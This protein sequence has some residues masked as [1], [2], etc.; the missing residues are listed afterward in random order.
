ME[1]DIDIE[2]HNVLDNP[3]IKNMILDISN[4]KTEIE[5]YDE[6]GMSMDIEENYHNIVFEENNQFKT[7]SNKII[8]GSKPS[9]S[10]LIQESESETTVFEEDN[11]DASLD[12]TAEPEVSDQDVY[13]E[14]ID[15]TVPAVIDQDVYPE[16][17]DVTLPIVSDQNVYP[18]TSILQGLLEEQ[19]F[20][21]KIILGTKTPDSLDDSDYTDN[22]SVHDLPEVSVVL[23]DCKNFLENNPCF[24]KDCEILFATDNDL[25]AHRMTVHS[26]LVAVKEER[27]DHVIPKNIAVKSTSKYAY[28]EHHNKL[29][30]NHCNVIFPSDIDLLKHTYELLPNKSFRKVSGSDANKMAHYDSSNLKTTTNLPGMFFVCRICTCH[31]KVKI[32]LQTH[33]VLFHCIK[34][35]GE[36][37]PELTD[38]RCRIC[39][40]KVKNGKLYNLHVQLRHTD[41]YRKICAEEP[42]QFKCHLCSASFSSDYSLRIHLAAKHSVVKKLEIEEAPASSKN[43]TKTV[44][45]G[46]NAPVPK[47]TIFKCNKCHVHF[48]SCTTAVTHLR[49]CSLRGDFRCGR[50]RRHFNIIEKFDHLHQHNLT[51]RFRVIDIS[52]NILNKILCK[53]NKCNTCFDEVSLKSHTAAVCSAETPAIYCPACN[54]WINATAM[55]QHKNIHASG[56]T[57]SDFI[58][59]V[60]VHCNAMASSDLNEDLDVNIDELDKVKVKQEFKETK[61][62][63]KAPTKIVKLKGSVRKG[64]EKR[65][66]RSD[67]MAYLF[68]PTCKCYMK[69]N[70][71]TDK[72]CIGQCSTK[73]PFVTCKCCGLKF[74]QK[75]YQSHCKIHKKYPKLKLK[76]MNFTN[77]QTYNRMN[78][79]FPKFE[80]CKVCKVSFF[81]V[82]ALKSHVCNAEKPKLCSHCDR[83]F[84]DLAYNLHV[85]FYEYPHRYKTN[86]NVKPTN[87]K[88]SKVNEN[89]PELMKKYK[90]LKQIWNILFLC[91]TCDI[92]ID[93]YDRVVEHCQD[94]FCNM[95]SYNVTI[96]RCDICNLNFVDESFKKHKELHS[97]DDFN[98]DSFKIIEYSYDNLL[99]NN[100]LQIFESLTQEQINLILSKSMY[101]YSRCVRMKLIRNGPAAMVLYQC[102]Q[103]KLIVVPNKITEHSQNINGQCQT[104]RRFN[105]SICS[106]KFSYKSHKIVHEKLHE[107]RKVTA[108]SFKIVEF[109]AE[110]QFTATEE[111]HKEDVDLNNV[112]DEQKDPD[113]LKFIRCQYCGKLINKH[114]YKK[115]CVYHYY[116]TRAKDIK[117]GNTAKGIAKHLFN[118]GKQEPTFYKCKRCEVC[119]S[120]GNTKFHKCKNVNLNTKC[121]KCSLF[122]RSKT[123]ASHYRLHEIYKFNKSNVNVIYFNKN[124]IQSVFVDKLKYGSKELVLYQCTECDICLWNK[125]SVRRHSCSASDKKGVCELCGVAY[126]LSRREAH[127]SMHRARNF[128]SSNVKLIKFR[129]GVILNSAARKR[130]PEDA[131]Q[132]TVAKKSRIEPSNENDEDS[133]EDDKNMKISNNKVATSLEVSMREC[134]CPIYER[135]FKCKTCKLLF[136]S[137]VV[138]IDHEYKC[139]GIKHATKC[140]DCGLVFHASEID[141]HTNLQKC[142]LTVA[143]RHLFIYTIQQLGKSYNLASNWIVLCAQCQIY[144]ISIAG[145]YH[146]LKLNHAITF[147]VKNCSQC[148]ITFTSTSYIK[149]RKIHHLRVSTTISDMSIVVVET[150]TLKNILKDQDNNEELTDECKAPDTETEQKAINTKTKSNEIKS[151]VH[152]DRTSKSNES[153]IYRCDICDLNFIHPESLKMHQ[154]QD[155]HNQVKYKCPKCELNFTKISLKKHLKIHHRERKQKNRNINTDVNDSIVESV[156]KMFDDNSSIDSK[157]DVIDNDL[158]RTR[159]FNESGIYHC[160]ICDLNFIHPESLKIHQAQGKHNQVKYKCPKCELNFTNISLKKHLHIHH[161]ERKQK[162]RNI[163]TDVNDSVVES[164]PKMFDDN[165]SIDSKSDVIDSESI[166]ETSNGTLETNDRPNTSQNDITSNKMETNR[167]ELPIDNKNET[168]NISVTH[169]NDTTVSNDIDELG[170]KNKPNSN[171]AAKN[172][173][174]K[175]SVCDVYYLTAD[176]CYE[177]T[178]SHTELDATE[179]IACKVCDLQFCCEFL[180]R[181]M[182]THREKTFC[183]DDLTVVE[184][185]PSSS[186]LTIDTYLAADRLKTKVSTTTHFDTDDDKSVCVDS[187]T[188][189]SVT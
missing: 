177:H 40:F 151:Q 124:S 8:V 143:Q 82:I 96:Q 77:L 181:H 84:S 21:N 70:R 100:W 125:V 183:T 13:P 58:L 116:Y 26:F 25:H 142:H 74:T 123:I 112:Q 56:V 155:K 62:P 139:D 114:K 65:F 163:N 52:K 48:V 5:D 10:T 118:L 111:K 135:F 88:I 55:P 179:F 45:K 92:I 64:S 11:P 141:S 133:H 22:E 53:C 14:T 97:S 15:V 182:K 165:S 178:V 94:H 122:F 61:A 102:G 89:I 73:H 158:A 27:I 2:E 105:C 149:H 51:D 91:Q 31:F 36:V 148:N 67:D 79:P 12:V 42:S 66:R 166:S 132:E 130:K 71:I 76:D 173:I 99:T 80:Q 57:A 152:L 30:C 23:Q 3:L 50:C 35:M 137:I 128:N 98:K 18:E 37:K 113:G 104:R 60:Y 4:I 72:H 184:Y 85:Q 29:L 180:G 185:R 134:R 16:T 20:P 156:P 189:E 47:S 154:S 75:G 186:G 33:L 172:K 110:K 87:N 126:I 46:Y 81:S 93:S 101:K 69:A 164:V 187:T 121:S 146:H 131:C 174:F 150:V 24:C 129:N 157:S 83:K 167:K 19:R 120:K 103:C 34:D 44:S 171:T 108:T 39:D 41:V 6:Q 7:L 107:I 160:D 117:D 145:M 153:G 109:Q 170:V 90:S 106:L 161:R 54:H 159:N 9:T 49:S 127:M 63:G 138:L 86:A 28:N 136:V 169:K 38:F 140:T 78:P 68:C 175:C 162:N 95:E 17:M 188:S 43:I 176:D 168:R 144:N 59:T 115:H 32:K 119:V 147:P 1:D